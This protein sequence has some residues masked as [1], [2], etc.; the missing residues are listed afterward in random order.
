MEIDLDLLYYAGH[1]TGNTRLIDIATT[2]A[3]TVLR[4]VVRKDWSTFHLVNFDAKTGEVKARLTNQGYKDWS[5]WSRY[6]VL[7]YLQY[8]VRLMGRLLTQLHN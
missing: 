7:N 3:K 5:T 1:H 6:A 4:T 8:D 2:H